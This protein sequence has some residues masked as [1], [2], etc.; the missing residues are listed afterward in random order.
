MQKYIKTNNEV[1]NIPILAESQIDDK[2]IRKIR[3]KY[4]INDELKMARIG[5]DTQEWIEY[6]DYVEECRAWG[7]SEKAQAEVDMETWA[8]F[9]WDEMEETREEFIARLEAEG[10]L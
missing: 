2:I 7:A 5:N 8:D 1:R 4:S 10:L 3:Q 9:Q 6:N